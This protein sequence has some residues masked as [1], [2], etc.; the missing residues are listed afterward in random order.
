M[1]DFSDIFIANTSTEACLYDVTNPSLP[2]VPLPLLTDYE[3]SALWASLT[4]SKLTAAYALIFID[5][6]SDALLY[7]LPPAFCNALATLNEKQIITAAAIW[8]EYEDIPWRKDKA[9]L[10]I[11][12]IHTLAKRAIAEN[13]A[14]YLLFI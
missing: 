13:K 3:I 11:Q 9:Q 8:S 6:D 10:K 7:Q 1:P 2:H 5:I 12:E 14:L 4:N